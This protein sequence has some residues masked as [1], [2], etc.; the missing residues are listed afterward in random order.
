MEH[1][2]HNFNPGPAALPLSVL[3]EIREEFLSFRGSGMSLTEISHRSPQFEEVLDDAIRRTRRLL[4][5]TDEYHVLFIQGGASMQFCM[6]PMNFVL[7]GKP[8]NYINT[9]V[10]SAKAIKE[11]QQQVQQVLSLIHI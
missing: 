9:G 5:L 3:K 2:I 7:P 4:N 6:I 11:A 8:P 1:R 10:W